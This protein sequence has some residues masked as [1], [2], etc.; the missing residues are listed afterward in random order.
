M[1]ES[2]CQKSLI[3][4]VSINLCVLVMYECIHFPEEARLDV[5]INNAGVLRQERELSVDGHELMFA[6]NFLGRVIKFQFCYL[7]DSFEMIS[8]PKT[9]YIVRLIICQYP[10]I[11]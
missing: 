4:F 3:L 5:L 9:P 1:D 8:N 7:L 10:L 2:I 6:V 11:T